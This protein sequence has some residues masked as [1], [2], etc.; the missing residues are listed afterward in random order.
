MSLPTDL[1]LKERVRSAVDIV[2]VVG[3]TLELQPQGR[4]FVTRCPWHNDRR[5]SMTVNQERQ[6][7][8]CWPC[9]IGGDVFSF[10]MRRDGVDFP[11]AIRSL[12]ELAGIPLDQYTRGQKRTNPGDP[13]DRETLF[14]AMKL[15]CEDYFNIL[16][17]GQSDDAKIAREYLASRGIDDE[18]RKRFQIGFAP[19]EWS[20]AVDLLK[21]N[22]FSGAVAQAAGIA[23]AKRSG[24]GE[25]DMFRGRLMFPIHDLQNRPIAM[26]GRLIPAIAAKHG[27][28]AGA[29]YYNGRETL[30]FRKS[31]Q[32]YG[33][34][35]AREAIRREGQV[36]VMEGYTDVVAARQSGVETAV[37]VLGTALGENHVKILKRFAQRVVLV[38]DGDN[39]GQTRADQV[40]ELFVGADVDLRVLTLPEGND[41]ADYL[42]SQGRESFDRLV[43]ESPD[44][45][46]HKL[47][48]LTNGIDFTRDTHAVT[49]AVDTMLKIVAKAPPSLRVD[50]LLVRLSRSFELKTERLEQRLDVLR[51]EAKK[52]DSVV[53]RPKGGFNSNA[54]PTFEGVQHPAPSKPASASF[55]PGFDPNAAFAESADFGDDY[56]VGESHISSY[57][58]PSFNQGRGNQGR[59]QQGRGNPSGQTS[60]SSL[61]GLDRQLFETLIE[62]PDLA[63]MAVEAIDPDWFESRTA[64]MLMTAYQD[65][66]LA[67]RD[68][69]ADSLL[70]LVENEQLKN[71]IVTMQERVR[72]REGKLPETPEERYTMIM[73]RYRERGF[74]IEQKTQIEKL[75]SAS[76]DEDEEMAL[77]NR[78]IEED[79]QRRGI[80]TE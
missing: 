40:L 10:V 51:D 43:V 41:P 61:S 75:A 57:G 76:M 7:W 80:K 42:Q 78:L 55:D 52:R 16:E 37:A 44:A 60:M 22:N 28:N 33:L 59:G 1:D 69:D 35:L 8:K 48:R 15:V 26:G 70:L 79:R 24:T 58:S 67:G 19:D 74:S 77:L 54:K 6:T 65:L 71:Q 17:S 13:D 36:L 21:E 3:A 39:A 50:Q 73:T 2:D 32:L 62:S 14:A 38:L 46:D 4:N 12:A 47:S 11:T 56:Y 30:L 53:K 66:E 49:T 23:S 5:P 20:Y 72:D 68:L 29:K 9:D 45:L 63:A 18:N 34:Q 31:H 25:V 27:E 64:V